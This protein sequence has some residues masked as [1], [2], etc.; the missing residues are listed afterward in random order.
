MTIYQ[1][2]QYKQEGTNKEV[3]VGGYCHDAV[4]PSLLHQIPSYTSQVKR[5]GHKPQD[6][7]K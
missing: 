7:M 3:I 4:T 2:S 6:E 5:L 1:A